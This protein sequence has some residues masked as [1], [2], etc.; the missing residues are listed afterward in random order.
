MRLSH[1]VVQNDI[2]KVQRPTKGLKKG[3]GTI[4]TVEGLGFTLPSLAQQHPTNPKP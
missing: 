3:G 1:R 2:V 4:A